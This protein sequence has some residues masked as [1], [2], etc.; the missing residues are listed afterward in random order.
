MS[1]AAGE[2]LIEG[3]GGLEH[4][5]REGGPFG[6]R[7]LKS[8]PVGSILVGPAKKVQL[9]ALGV[10]R[11]RERGYLKAW[12]GWDLVALGG[13]GLARETENRAPWARYQ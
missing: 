11:M 3:L 2:D 12:G 9:L 1:W 8:S 5:M 6:A 7:N 10:C 13:T 4:G